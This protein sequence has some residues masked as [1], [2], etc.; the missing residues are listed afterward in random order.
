MIVGLV[1]GLLQRQR[2]GTGG[3]QAA[4]WLTTVFTAL[5]AIFAL[6]PGAGVV[7][8]VE[9]RTDVTVVSPDDAPHLH[10]IVNRMPAQ[11]NI[12]SPAIAVSESDVPEA[13]IVG[14]RPSKMHLV[15]SAGAIETLDDDELIAVM[16]HELAHV[17]NWDAAVM[18]ALST[19]SILA[20]APTE[21]RR[22]RHRLHDCCW[23][24]C[25]WR[26]TVRLRRNV[27]SEGS[28]EGHRRCAR[29]RA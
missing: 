21:S 15:L 8:A 7:N 29:P 9:Q 18:T 13:M 27:G 12:P 19:P 26:E 14:I 10:A 20:G 28:R 6:R 5:F 22:R 24:R 3:A 23:D 2:T 25:D 1:S 11:L 16:A 17:A 4:S